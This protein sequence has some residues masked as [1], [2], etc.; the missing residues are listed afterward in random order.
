MSAAA[1]MKGMYPRKLRHIGGKPCVVEGS[2]FDDA[3]E[4]SVNGNG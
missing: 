2:I 3:L 4:K 1:A